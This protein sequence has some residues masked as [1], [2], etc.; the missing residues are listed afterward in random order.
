MGLGGVGLISG[1]NA[2][3]THPSCSPEN[4]II[5]QEPEMGARSDKVP[6]P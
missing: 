4:H 3:V 1:L 2:H 5:F 6:V